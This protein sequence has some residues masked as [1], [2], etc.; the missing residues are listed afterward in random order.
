M[1]EE[2]TS[3][4][5]DTRLEPILPWTLSHSAPSLCP[6]TS[7]HFMANH[8]KETGGVTVNTQRQLSS[9]VFVPD[10]AQNFAWSSKAGP[11]VVDAG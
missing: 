11:G 4:T 2:L 1:A 3:P 7:P 9:V 8:S 10:V 6:F 5:P